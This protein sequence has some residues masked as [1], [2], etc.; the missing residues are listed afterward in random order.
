VMAETKKTFYVC[1]CIKCDNMAMPFSS[2]EER[3]KWLTKH[4]ESGHD[5][6]LL[7]TVTV[8]A[9]AVK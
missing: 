3:V 2:H 9:K 7:D 1:V 5:T 4:M 6:F 8:T